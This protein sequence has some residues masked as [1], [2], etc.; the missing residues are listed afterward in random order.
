MQIRLIPLFFQLG[1][2]SDNNHAT[3]MLTTRRPE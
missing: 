2:S 1:L 3:E